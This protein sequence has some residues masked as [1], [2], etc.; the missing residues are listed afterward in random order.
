[1]EGRAQQPLL[2]NGHSVNRSGF[3]QQWLLGLSLINTV[4]TDIPEGER[5]G[6]C[7]LARPAVR[8][9]FSQQEQQHWLQAALVPGNFLARVF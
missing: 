6:G 7:G 9:F 4:C 5:E 1:M 3:A 2:F 8:C